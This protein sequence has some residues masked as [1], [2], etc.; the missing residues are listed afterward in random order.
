MTL[1]IIGADRAMN[2]FFAALVIG[3]LA[4]GIIGSMSLTLPE[5]ERLGAISARLRTLAP[6]GALRDKKMAR[7]GRHAP[8]PESVDGE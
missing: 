8:E 3:C 7:N 6:I 4:A 5:R 1:G 2:L